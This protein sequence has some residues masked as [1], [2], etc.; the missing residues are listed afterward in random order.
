MYCCFGKPWQT[1]ACF[2]LSPGPGHSNKFPNWVSKPVVRCDWDGFQGHQN[3]Q[4]VVREIFMV[5]FLIFSVLGL[6]NGPCMDLC[7]ALKEHLLSLSREK[8]DLSPYVACCCLLCSFRPVE[9]HCLASEPAGTLPDDIY[10]CSGWTQLPPNTLQPSVEVSSCPTLRINHSSAD[11]WAT[12]H[13]LCFPAYVYHSFIFQMFDPSEL[14]GS[15][16]H[17]VFKIRSGDL[18]RSTCVIKEIRH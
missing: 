1:K 17:S 4:G 8:N 11:S 14:H 7:G 12:V 5:W 6:K 9:S 16:P 3:P 15:S 10:R 13:A 2:I 18:S